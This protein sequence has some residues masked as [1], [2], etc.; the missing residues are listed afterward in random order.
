[1]IVARDEINNL[2]TAIQTSIDLQDILQVML[3]R[4][5]KLN[6]KYNNSDYLVDEE[7]F[8]GDNNNN[9]DNDTL[10]TPKFD[11]FSVSTS[12]PVRPPFCSFL[13]STSP[14][15]LSSPAALRPRRSRSSSRSSHSSLSASLRRTSSDIYTANNEICIRV[16]KIKRDIEAALTATENANRAHQKRNYNFVQ[17]IYNQA[18]GVYNAPVIIQNSMSI[19]KRLDELIRKLKSK[20]NVY[21]TCESDYKKLVDS[22][23]MDVEYGR[24][25][26]VIT[27]D[28]DVCKFSDSINL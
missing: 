17:S 4:L 5:Q 20:Y 16:I 13:S 8:E 25:K 10:A 11:Q 6:K 12:T 21:Q 23:D 1:M 26:D 22:V 15:N 14:F 9:N 18:D 24:S 28:G 27:T 2:D 3:D 19:E 7:V